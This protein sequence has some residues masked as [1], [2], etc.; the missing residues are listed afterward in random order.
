VGGVST[1][2]SAPSS[3]ARTP[4]ANG[5]QAN[6]SPAVNGN[7]AAKKEAKE[8]AVAGADWS[9]EEMRLM[10][11][12][13]K[14]FPKGYKARWEAIAAYL[15]KDM[16]EVIKVSKRFTVDG[17]LAKPQGSAYEKFQKDKAAN[18]SSGK[19]REVR[20]PTSM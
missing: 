17:N 20:E 19:A 2:D 1:G 12:A 11:K 7:S 13:L 14:K 16:D 9:D 4:V 5:K 15:G 3:P 18:L 8:E 10:A 6:G